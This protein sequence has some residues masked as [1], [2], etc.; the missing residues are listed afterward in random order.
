M[1]NESVE[2]IIKV[3]YESESQV[4]KGLMEVVLLLSKEYIRSFF[5]DD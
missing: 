4:E 3:V 5:I 1:H 2:S